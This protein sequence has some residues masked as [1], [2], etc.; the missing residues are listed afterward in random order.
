MAIG[1][2]TFTGHEGSHPDWANPEY[3]HDGDTGSKSTTFMYGLGPSEWLYVTCD[4]TAEATEVRF[5]FRSTDIGWVFPFWRIEANV[6]GGWYVGTGGYSN[7]PI[8]RGVSFPAGTLTQARF[9]IFTYYSHAYNT[10]WVYE[11]QF[12][13]PGDWPPTIVGQ[14]YFFLA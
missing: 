13:T 6:D 5:L 9:Q 10:V 1:W 4:P 3:A 2:N 11:A 14:T 12:Y 8:W 7:S